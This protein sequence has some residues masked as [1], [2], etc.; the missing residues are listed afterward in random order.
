VRFP[1]NPSDFAPFLLQA[2]S[3]G[4][5]IVAIASTGADTVNAV[6]QAHEFG[7][8]G[9]GLTVVGMLTF[10]ADVH[11]LGLENAQGMYVASQYYWDADEGTRAFAKRF[12]DIE[13]KMP[14]KLQAATYAAVHHYLKAVE[15]AGTDEALAVNAQMRKMPVDFFGQTAHVRSDGR[16]IYDL[17]LYRVK[18]P[19]ESKYPWD[20]Y[21]KIATIAG[22]D[23]FRPL[24]EGGCKR[25]LQP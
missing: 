14:T 3:S 6:K 9:S 8:Q 2:Q 24:G 22:A 10:L 5:K 17:S 25:D 20:Y 21:T 23:A 13:K 12:F 4:A 7:L 18:K 1:F 15:A 19:A 16:V 11:T